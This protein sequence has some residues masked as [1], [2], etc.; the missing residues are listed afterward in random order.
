[1]KT[2]LY[3]RAFNVYLLGWMMPRL[4][5]A[6]DGATLML[7]A[8]LPQ[9]AGPGLRVPTWAGPALGSLRP[10]LPPRARRSHCAARAAS[11]TDSVLALRSRARQGEGVPCGWA[12]TRC[13]SRARRPSGMSNPNATAPVNMER[14]HWLQQTCHPDSR[15]Q[16]MAAHSAASG[17]PTPPEGCAACRRCWPCSACSAA[18]GGPCAR[19]ASGPGL[20]AGAAPQPAQA[21]PPPPPFVRPVDAP[22]PAKRQAM[23]ASHAA[24][25]QA[26][27]CCRG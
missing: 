3:T 13:K 20:A 22:P 9:D 6:H 26:A 16:C 24:D 11:C 27:R 5:V 23:M 21:Q 4:I 18:G 8:A 2:S 1:M 14:A 17:V 10:L 7:D 25:A 19:C 15:G 12:P